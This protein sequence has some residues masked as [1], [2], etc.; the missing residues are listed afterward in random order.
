MQC[1]M[2]HTLTTHKPWSDN[3]TYVT[4]NLKEPSALWPIVTNCKIMLKQCVLSQPLLFHKESVNPCGA[5]A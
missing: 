1:R 4:A 2:Y 3:P 5:S